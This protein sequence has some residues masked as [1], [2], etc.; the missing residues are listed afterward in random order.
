MPTG[1]PSRQGLILFAVQAAGGFV[2]RLFLSIA[3]G[4]L[5]KIAVAHPGCAGISFFQTHI[6]H[7]VY[8]PLNRLQ[9]ASRRS[10]SCG[11]YIVSLSIASLKST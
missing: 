8:T 4:D 7:S 11:L 2:E 6:R 5:I 10:A 9:C 3:E 1:Q